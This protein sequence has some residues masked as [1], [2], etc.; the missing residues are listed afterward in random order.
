VNL[1]TIKKSSKKYRQKVPKAP[2]DFGCIFVHN[3]MAMKSIVLEELK[4]LA[5]VLSAKLKL[6]AKFRNL[7]VHRYWT[8]DN[9]RV[10]DIIKQDISVVGEYVEA[11]DSYIRQ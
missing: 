9:A 1:C 5:P 3:E 6:M 2:I 11:V 10:Y 8:I 4:I 7:L